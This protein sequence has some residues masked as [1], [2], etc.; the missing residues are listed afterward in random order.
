MAPFVGNSFGSAQQFNLDLNQATSFTDSVNS[1][2]P[3]DFYRVVVSEACDLSMQ[4][5]SL[6][7]NA[8]IELYNSNKKLID[9]SSKAGDDIWS[10]AVEKGMYFVKVLTG[11]NT[12]ADYN[13]TLE[14]KTKGSSVTPAPLVQ[15]PGT[16]VAPPVVINPVTPPV[17]INPVTPPVVVNPITPPVVVNPIAP[18]V[19][20]NP[21]APPVIVNPIVVNPIAPSPIVV[22]PAVTPAS[23]AAAVLSSSLAGSSFGAAKEFTLGLNSPVNVS[24]AINPQAP[25]DF[26]R[27]V[28]SNSSDLSLQLQSL[29]GDANIELYNGNKKLIA[30]SSQVGNDNLTWAV[31]KGTYFVKVIGS[32]NTSA[33]YSLTLESKTKS[34]SVSPTPI[35]QSVAPIVQS[36]DQIIQSV[37]AIVQQ[38]PIIQPAPIQ[39][40]PKDWFDLNLGDSGLRSAARSA[41]ADGIISR[42]DMLSL[43]RAAADVNLTGNLDAQSVDGTELKDLQTI[44]GG[45]G[46]KIE[47]S[48]QVL[49][50]KVINGDAANAWYTG[51]GTRQ[52]L[53]NLQSNSSAGQ[54][55]QLVNKWFLGLD[56]PE[57]LATNDQYRAISGS[58][59]QNGISLTDIDQ[60]N[61]GSCYFLA[62]LG[63]IANDLTS[64]IQSMFTDN[65]DGTFTVRFYKPTG[66][67]D[68]VTVDRFLPTD[69]NGNLVY[70]GVG[71]NAS[72]PGNELWVAL[73][74]KAYA[75]LN[76]SGWI[77]RRESQNSYETIDGG[78]PDAPLQQI[79]GKAVNEAYAPFMAAQKVI[80]I[81]NANQAITVG[82][83]N[84]GGQFGLVEG[85][86]YVVK[87]Y[88]SIKQQFQ[89]FNPWGTNHV[90]LNWSQIGSAQGFVSWAV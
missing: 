46:Y 14:A 62:A 28:V 72:N 54:L 49:A 82:F 79:S 65:S 36:V 38:A 9:Q 53:G 43:F 52:A 88:D 13:L 32:Q 24:D 30:Q 89:L 69:G 34:S 81:V 66:Q 58:L 25:A 19:V 50:N 73:A 11:Q 29:N 5:K 75:Q 48:V 47:D 12:S 6:N 31:E 83:S 77:G 1:Q 21:I 90:S 70:S 27:V 10:R 37:A 55:N 78:W 15:P 2:G 60:G 86:A 85:H 57:T 39:P 3:F 17:V 67:A 22:V 18:P 35:A 7:G 16:G 87:T 71:G 74:E 51:S 84:S 45:S 42:T 40:A 8:N 61:L 64:T 68:Y 23:P 63:S 44:V 4:L 20:V 33:D 41:A 80:D 76:E 59:F 26:Y 56:R